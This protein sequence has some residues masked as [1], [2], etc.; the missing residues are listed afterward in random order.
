[1]E[2]LHCMEIL[3]LSVYNIDYTLIYLEYINLFSIFTIKMP[4]ALTAL[5]PLAS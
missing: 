1:M 4:G 2:K 3:G 5:K